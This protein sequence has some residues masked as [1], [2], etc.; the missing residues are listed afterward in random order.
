MGLIVPAKP[1]NGSI[2]LLVVLTSLSASHRNLDLDLLEQISVGAHS[3]LPSIVSDDAVRGVVVVATCNR[4]EVYLDAADGVV[5]AARRAAIDAVAAETGLAV[6]DV[7][8]HL[9]LAA[10]DEPSSTCSPSPLG[11]TRW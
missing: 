2:G 6:E 10:G 7:A 11:S 9:Q 5:P 3:V 8:A 4:F 1:G